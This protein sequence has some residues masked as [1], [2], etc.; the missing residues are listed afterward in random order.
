MLRVEH[1]AR[2]GLAGPDEVP[3]LL[4]HDPDDGVD[5][6]GRVDAFG[7]VD[8]LLEQASPPR[9]HAVGN[10]FGPVALALMRLMS[11]QLR[12]TSRSSG[13]AGLPARP[14]WA[15]SLAS[16]RLVESRRDQL[17]QRREGRLGI[18]PAGLQLEPGA[19]SGGQHRQVQDAL[20]VDPQAVAIDP[21]L[22]REPPGQADEPV[23]G[24][25]VQAEGVEDH[26]RR[27][28]V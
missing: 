22:G 13:I 6:V 24:P 27:R 20:A 16:V 2:R 17:G 3:C 15:V 26:D 1:H 10:A 14:S 12:G 7:D 9:R 21:N 5:V 28:A 19:A 23:R 11:M 18:R 8:E 25:Q 4:G